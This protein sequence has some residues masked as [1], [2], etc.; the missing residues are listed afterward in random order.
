MYISIYVYTLALP[1]SVAR[2][3][4]TWGAGV[5]IHTVDTRP[6]LFQIKPIF[7]FDL[8]QTNYRYYALIKWYLM[9]CNTGTLYQ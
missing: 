7:W 1:N 8:Y 2:H 6:S 9:I 3:A 5:D 4:E